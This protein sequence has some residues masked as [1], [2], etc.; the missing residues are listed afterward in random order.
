MEAG[1]PL[2]HTI[3]PKNEEIQSM[4]SSLKHSRGMIN[5]RE[6]KVRSLM[7]D[8]AFSGKEDF[9]G[10]FAEM[11]ANIMLSVRHLEDARM[12][13]GKVIQQIDGGISIYDK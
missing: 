5:V 3:M 4:K 1:K 11:K 10:Q 6:N 12:R 7:N 13:L 2:I 8:E 9:P